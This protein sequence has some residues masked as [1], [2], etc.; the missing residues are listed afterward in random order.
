M[1]RPL[2]VTILGC[3]FIVAGVVGLAYHLSERPLDPGGRAHFR[4][5]S[6]CCRGWSVPAEGAQLGS[7]VDN[8]VA[9]LSRWGE[10]IPLA[11]GM[12]SACSVVPGCGLFPANAS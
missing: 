4:H 2:P 9:W 3:L 6:T 7:L 11:V 10:R 1:K 8:W 5:S 12:Y